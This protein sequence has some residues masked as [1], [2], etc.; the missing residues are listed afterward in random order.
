MAARRDSD[1]YMLSAPHTRTII[2]HAS[3]AGLAM[4]SQAVGMRRRQERPGKRS[5]GVS[6]K[7]FHGHVEM[8]GTAGH[9]HGH[10]VQKNVRRGPAM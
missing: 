10:T 2:I 4:I 9:G 5:S 8:L 3:P 7:T 6:Q 1:K